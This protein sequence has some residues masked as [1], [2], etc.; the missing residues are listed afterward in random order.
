MINVSNNFKTLSCAATRDIDF[1]IL[2]NNNAL[3]FIQAREITDIEIEQ[4]GSEGGVGIG[5]AVSS[6][7]TFS[8]NSTFE[9]GEDFFFTPQVRFL[10]TTDSE[11]L[12][13]GV[14]EGKNTP[15][16]RSTLTITAYDALYDT[17]V[18]CTWE[19]RG[20]SISALTFPASMQQMLNYV[21]SVMRIT[22]AFTCENF[23]VNEKPED[24]TCREIL[25]FIAA[26]HAGNCIIDNTGKFNI[27]RFENTNTEILKANMIDM[28]INSKSPFKVNGVAFHRGGDIIF[29]DGD[30]QEYSEERPGVIHCDNPLV[31][32]QI[33]EYVWNKIGGMTYHNCMIEKQGFGYFQCGDMYSVIPLNSDNDKPLNIVITSLK[34]NFNASAGFKETL[35]S[36]ALS[37]R[38]SANRNSKP[39]VSTP[40]NWNEG[41]GTGDGG[42]S[43]YSAF[44]FPNIS[45]ITD[46]VYNNIPNK[47]MIVIYNP[48]STINNPNT[49]NP[50]NGLF[51]I[52]TSYYKNI[53]I[54]FNKGAFVGEFSGLFWGGVLLPNGRIILIPLS[55]ANVGIYNPATDTF[56]NGAAHGRG[57]N[58]FRG[59]V[60]LPD[61]R[62]IFV[63][64]SSVIGIYN[65]A[66]DTYTNGP[67]Q[68]RGFDAFTGG[69]L[70]PDRRVIFVPY[71]STN[72]GI[73]NSVTNTYT[74]GAAHGRG[75]TAFSEGVLLPDGRVI[76][77]P[78]GSPNVGIYD[79]INNTYTNGPT[80]GRGV[81]AF[82]G[83]VLLPDGRVV[84]VPY[85][86]NN[87]GI[88]NPATNTYT[89]GGP[90]ESGSAFSGGV[91]LS[92][93]RIIFFPYGKLNIGILEVLK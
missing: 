21:C 64:L 17:D 5:N 6:R 76:F 87:V 84:F 34:Y 92:D 16:K 63:P 29:I 75:T 54:K 36:E 48:A 68:D 40:F 9:W 7:L 51:A 27:K 79:P 71:G 61:G 88:Y 81:S 4:T 10:G 56:T 82:M 67:T 13:L 23:I 52:T 47:S 50:F 93:G 60:L 32:I 62:V 2:L 42:G 73:Y 91:L 3:M 28:D 55:G 15:H 38:Q 89:N 69:V 53:L 1:R 8:M 83:G 58:A 41:S 57:V 80:H 43:G 35:I 59:G 31:T 65:P 78:N 49:N 26:S 20:T 14:Y 33:A 77:V 39:S 24:Y 66:T 22:N 86:S 18:P 74:N 45:M 12:S 85:R 11:W 19:G 44:G 90:H 70:L 25:R 37:E 30:E 46:E 72:V